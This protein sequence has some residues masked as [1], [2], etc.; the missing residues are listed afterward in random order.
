MTLSSSRPGN[1]L[2]SEEN[3]HREVEQLHCQ[4]GGNSGALTEWD[5]S[6]ILGIKGPSTRGRRKHRKPSSLFF[7]AEGSRRASSE[8][9][10]CARSMFYRSLPSSQL[11]V[12]TECVGLKARGDT[13][14]RHLR[15]TSQCLRDERSHQTTKGGQVEK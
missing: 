1:P 11:G 10:A 3:K 7:G 15:M 8:Y 6:N 13:K 4:S 12:R 2:N 14:K 9:V 5:K